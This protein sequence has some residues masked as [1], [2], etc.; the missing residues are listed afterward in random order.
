M[1]PG[2]TFIKKCSVCLKPIGQHTLNSD[3]TSGVVVWT[4]G[5]VTYPMPFDRPKLVLCPHCRAPVWL[6]ELEVL[7]KVVP[8]DAGYGGM[9]DV[10][11]YDPL[12]L[13][14]YFVQI[15]IG[16]T[17]PE[18]ER[19]VRGRA[20]WAGNDE[21]RFSAH[22]IPL[23]PRETSNLTA[24]LQTLD[25]SDGSELVFKAEILRELGRFDEALS[26]FLKSVDE[27]IAWQVKTIGRLAEG[28]DP[29]VREMPLG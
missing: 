2:P 28:R 21:R 29:Y 20:L 23:S 8:P 22:E 12:S 18:K 26:L 24:I 5:K 10:R 1:K 16:F 15:E 17:E 25:E 9:E 7:G 14:D 27:R 13:D 4:D 19:Y 11:E 6:T 3:D